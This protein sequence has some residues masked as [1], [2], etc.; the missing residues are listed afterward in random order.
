MAWKHF[1]KA[2][3]GVQIIRSIIRLTIAVVILA[4]PAIAVSQFQVDGVDF[5]WPRS[6]TASPLVEAVKANDAEKVNRLLA[7]GADINGLHYES[8]TALMVAVSYGRPDILEALLRQGADPNASSKNGTTALMM[9]IRQPKVIRMLLD[10]GADVNAKDQ[11][12]GRSALMNAFRSGSIPAIDM[13][14]E[15]GANLH[16]TDKRGNNVLGVASEGG[17][18]QAIRKAL[19]LGFDPNV[20]DTA[21]EVHPLRSATG[22]PEALKVLIA[23]GAKVNA[24]SRDLLFTALHVAAQNGYAESVKILIKA[25][26]DV[27]L[28]DFDGHT[29]LD[30]ATRSKH[31]KVV[32]LLKDA[33]AP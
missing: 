28:R 23:A 1:V 13:L 9:A 33:G 10:A 29:P 8:E 32:E 22:S 6:G 26:A 7:D 15:A 27:K 14:L 16:A 21:A 2:S 20:G 18:A 12:W 31:A 17:D 3:Q 5:Q 4:F 30:R 25:G 24:R 11:T 19:E